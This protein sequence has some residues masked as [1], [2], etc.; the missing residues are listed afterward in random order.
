MDDLANLL[1][2]A[3]IE[4]RA[5][6]RDRK[7]LLHFFVLKVATAEWWF[8]ARPVWDKNGSDYG[9]ILG[10]FGA[11]GRHS[12]IYRSFS[13]SEIEEIKTFIESYLI[14]RDVDVFSTRLF[15]S[16]PHFIEFKT[17]WIIEGNGE[18]YDLSNGGHCLAPDEKAK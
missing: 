15:G 7:K 11:L 1:K 16:R 13:G 14:T 9:L 5:V 10:D 4:Y 3:T 6:S 12:F 17:P 2:D 18:N 8:N